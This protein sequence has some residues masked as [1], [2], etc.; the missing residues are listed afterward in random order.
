[1][2]FYQLKRASVLKSSLAG[3]KP[4]PTSVHSTVAID[5]QRQSKPRAEIMVCSHLACPLPSRSGA[6][7]ASNIIDDVLG[8]ISSFLSTASYVASDQCTCLFWSAAVV[9]HGRDIQR[10]IHMPLHSP[11][12]SAQSLLQYFQ[13]INELVAKLG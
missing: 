1:M 9:N 7:V 11:Y 4:I 12:G 13:A 2:M 5:L 6:S 3:Q 10:V 8:L